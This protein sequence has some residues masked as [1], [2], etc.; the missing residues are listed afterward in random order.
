ML[1]IKDMETDYT[2]PNPKAVFSVLFLAVVVFVA[3]IYYNDLFF[4][5]KSPNELNAPVA[6]EE[7]TGVPPLDTLSVDE[8]LQFLNSRGQLKV[9]ETKDKTS[10][11]SKNL[12]V[13]VLGLLSQADNIKVESVLYSNGKKGF[14]VMF[15][16]NRSSIE[17]FKSFASSVDRKIWNIFSASY[18]EKA[19]TLSMES[20]SY[21]VDIDFAQ[22]TYVKTQVKMMVLM[23]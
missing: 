4:F 16:M 10:V 9:P 8:Q 14:E 11:S 15:N 1:I 7:R 3:L 5:K 13:L 23:K 22:E 20:E 21:Q 6:T 12:P 19:A 17:S 18:S 2:K